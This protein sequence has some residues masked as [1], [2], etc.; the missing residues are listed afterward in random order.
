[1]TAPRRLRLIAFYKG[2]GHDL[3]AW[4][5]PDAPAYPAETDFEHIARFAEIAEAAHFD[6]VFLLDGVDFG[7]KERTALATLEP[8]VSLAA[9]SQRTR[10]I[11]LIG[12]ISTSFYPPYQIARMLA[13]LHRVSDGRIGWNIVTSTRDAEARNFGLD[14]IPDHAARYENAS[15][16]VSAVDRLLASWPEE[17]IVRDRA[18]GHYTDLAQVDT[19]GFASGRY[20]VGSALNIPLPAGERPLYVQATRSADGLR[21]AAR[22][23]DA[24]FSV[25][26]SIE[27]ARAF[28]AQ[29]RAA[30]PTGR[31][32]LYLPGI[33]PIIGS[34]QREAEDR[35]AAL[36]AYPDLAQ[37][38]RRF[39][40]FFPGVDIAGYDLDDRL[41]VPCDDEN[42]SSGSVG[43]QQIVGELV[44][45]GVRT[46][47][48]LDAE[49]ASSIGHFR[50]VGTPERVADEMEHWFR[51]G[52]VDGFTVL[53]PVIPFDL[54]L[55][56][57]HVVPLLV[58]RGLIGTDSD[59]P[60]G[61]HARFTRTA[62]AAA[63]S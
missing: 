13:T 29:L 40:K 53:P 45:G 4:R 48:E 9:L 20:S 56:C 39:A 14:G 5:T 19:S 62:D 50:V 10:R 55:F 28:R 23:A 47:R 52:I 12:T 51:E 8:I 18:S 21:F 44:R 38:R 35:R 49:Y 16:F 34:T 30:R 31:P 27:D 33:W 32:L 54:E 17:S 26:G 25:T 1:M 43:R 11:G 6:G 36:L 37:I 2:V 3:N 24:V 63:A 61:L 59:E 60:T 57:E 58:A 22:H 42:V 46:L 15:D 41:P 7:E